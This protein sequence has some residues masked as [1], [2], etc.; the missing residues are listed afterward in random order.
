[1]GV[2]MSTS[3]LND[4]VHTVDNKLYPLYETQCENI[5]S[6]WLLRIDEVP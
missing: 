1:M 5:R 6:R 3:T 2:K 4:I